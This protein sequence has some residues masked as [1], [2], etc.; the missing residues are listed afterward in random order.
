MISS[1]WI[2]LCLSS[3]ETICKFIASRKSPIRAFGCKV[4]SR[5]IQG[6]SAL[7]ANEPAN[8]WGCISEQIATKDIHL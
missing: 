1:R 2:R 6:I 3:K 7:I 4:Q 8:C 5:D